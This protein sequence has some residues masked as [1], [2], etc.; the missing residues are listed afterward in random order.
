MADLEQTFIFYGNTDLDRRKTWYSSVAAA[1]DRLRPRYPKA[2]L[3]RATEIAGLSERSRILEVGCGPGTATV[4]L[5]GLGCAMT[6]LEPNADFYSLARANCRSFSRIEILNTSFE[7]WPLESRAFSTV[8]A[9]S[10]FHWIPR[11]IAYP[12]AADALQEGGY[13]VLFWNKELQPRHE[14]A[15]RFSELYR[16]H[17]PSLGNY[18]DRS[19][20]EE[21][22]NT[23]GRFVTDSG[24]FEEPVFE[25]METKITYTSEEYVT[26]LHT[27][28]PYLELSDRTR[29]ALFADLQ[30][31][32]DREF[33]GSLELTFVSA[34]HIARKK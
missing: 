9:A 33:G 11:E 30:D 28:S 12:K 24:R 31:C 5:A 26:L 20:R 17:A 13:L 25:E 7:E 18:E 29:S 27:Y 15:R 3:R 21:I 34:F 6:A 4:D 19:L 23:L 32:I 8:L 2:F 14:V 16:L 22:F 10:S 1:Y